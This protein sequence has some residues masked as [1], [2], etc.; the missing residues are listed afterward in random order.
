MPWSVKGVD[1]R[2]RDAAKAAARRAGMTLGEWLDNKIRDEAAE[3]EP[4]QAAPEQ[5]DI[6]ALSERLAKLS[7]GQMDTSPYAAASAAQ[8]GANELSRGEIDAVINQAAAAERLTRESSA[9]T[10]GALDSITRWIEKTES[11][12]TSSERAAA[13]RQERATSVIA[14]AIKTMGERLVEMERK[15]SEAQQAQTHA[16]PMPAPRLA[17]SRDGLAEAVNDIRTRQRALDV[18]GQAQPARRS[19]PENRIAALRQDLRELSN[20]IVPAS[21]EA[22]APPQRMRATPAQRPASASAPIQGNPIEAMLADLG[23]RLDKLDKHDRLDPIMKPLARIESDVSR[24]SQERSAEGYQRFELEIAHLAAKVDALVARGGDRSVIA[25]V[26]RD[27][28]ELRDMVR[29]PAADPRMDTLSRQISSLST[30][31]SQLREAQPDGR[32]IR[33]LSQ[34]IEDVRNAILSDRAHDRQADPTQLTSLSR[35]IENLADK[36]ETL[37]AMRPEVIN[38]QAEQLSARLNEM[39]A[40]GRGVS[41]VLSDRIEALV[42]RLEDM[43]GKDMAGRQPDQ[44]ESRIDALQESIETL[45]EQGPVAVT[46]QIEALAGRIESLAAASNLSQLISEGKG[47][48][49][50]RVDL[51]P[52]EDMLRGLAEK[53]DE[54]GRPGAET[55]A[56]D[57][58]EQ[59]ISGLAQRLDTAAA[60]R[61]AETGIERTL[62]DLV[63]HL[64]TLRQDTTAAAERAARAAM[65]DMGTKGGPA[66]GIAEISNLLSGLRDTHVSSG[67]ETQDA[68]GAVHQT[69][70]T[71]ISRLASIEAELAA[72]R[73]GPAPRAVMPPRHAEQA[74]STARMP[75][76]AASLSIAQEDRIAAD[77]IAAERPR[78]GQPE[79]SSPVA[80]SLDL[81]LEPGSGRPRVSTTTA[82]QDAQSVRQSLIAAARRSAKAATE[83]TTSPAATSEPAKGSGRLKEIMEKRRKPLLLGLAALVLAMGT[84]HVVTGALQGGGT[85]KPVSAEAVDIPAVPTAPAPVPATPTPAKDQTS[86]L[87]PVPAPTISTAP[88]FMSPTQA[89]IT[90]PEAAPAAEPL[91]AAS[92]PPVQTAVLMVTGVD[93]LPTGLGSVGLRKAALA[94]DARAVYEVASRAADGP[95]PARDPK[96]ALR[97]FE[98]AAVAGLAP[99]Q[100]RLGNMFEKGIGTTRD[101]SLARVWYTRA[102]ERGNAKAMHNLAVLHAEGA[103]GKPD[104]ATATEWFR[105]AAE[106]GVRDSQYNL[107]ILL[108]RGLGA[109]TDLGQSY[110]WFSIAAA[111]GDEDASRKRDEVAQRLSPG[112]LATAKAAA[113][114]W[115]PKALEATANDVAPPI[116]GWDEAPSAT[117]KKPAKPAHG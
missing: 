27:I 31:L 35:Q 14:D 23:A 62:Q 109:P 99:A 44:L 70:E 63:V 1:P 71:V 13:E 105:K 25:P 100:F 95:G 77:R 37:P 41:H 45:A 76:P 51:R 22:E 38:A 113:E 59:Q 61:S 110:L 85:G 108:G 40:S 32:E 116:K 102:A 90:I 106:L 79:A 43:A 66:S 56:F 114:S 3:T 115:K 57:A 36:I 68:I 50:A 19:V 112:D 26:L 84:A 12:I 17:F 2:T 24:L 81:P 10:A 93:D 103:S 75:E 82:P 60:T 6:A 39:D 67:R 88:A 97:L 65:A 104:Y 48:Q 58:L 34:A 16:K 96:L 18:D 52:I 101:A 64:Q 49:V 72:E 117:T 20:R 54:A 8:Q 78:A 4:E 111:Q 69:L 55:D 21:P 83:A 42:I 86:A 92:A 33:S 89:A 30:E 5:L 53:I 73:Q 28:A 29:A 91:P 15:A 94:G 98:R 107:A 80:A 7:Q 9:K 46:R 11:R 74:Q 87:P 47:P